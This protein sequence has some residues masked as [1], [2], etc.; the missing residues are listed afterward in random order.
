MS[1]IFGEFL[2]FDQPGHDS[3]R[4]RVFGDEHYA[5]YE[6]AAGYSVVFDPELGRYCYARLS[7]GT[8]QSTGVAAEASPPEGLVRH[9]QEDDEVIAAKAAGKRALRISMAA[10]PGA[11]EINRTFGPAQGLLNGRVLATGTVRGLTILVNFKDLQSTVTRGDVE[12]LL[13]SDNYTSNG[14]I[15]SVRE[16]FRRISS[17]KLDYVNT[18]VGPYTLSRNRQYYVRNLLV[19]EALG[20]AVADGLDLTLFDSRGEGLIDALNV[21]YAG[22]TQYAGELWPHNWSINLRFGNMRTDQYMLSSLGRSPR[23]LSIGTF[24]HETGHLLCRFPDLYD[25]GQREADFRPSAGIGYFCLMGAGNHLDYGRSPAPVCAYLRDLVGWVDQEIDLHQAGDHQV[26][27]G[28]YAT[29]HKYQTS[30]PNEYFLV[31]NRSRV[32][33]DRGGIASGLAIYH[34]DILGSNE[35][36]DGT[37]SRHYQCALLQ[38]DGRR[39][40]E[41]NSN[42]GDPA[43]LFGEFPDVALSSETNPHT[44]EWDGRDSGLTI[45]AIGRP[46]D[47]IRFRTGSQQPPPTSPVGGRA[48]PE[49]RIPDSSSSGVTSDIRIEAPGVV[50]RIIV[51][52]DIRHPYIG[53]L[54]VSLTAPSGRSTELHGRLGMGRDDLIETYDSASPGVLSPMLGEPASGIW[55]LTAK[56]LAPRDVGVLRSWEIELH[57]G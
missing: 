55:R 37:A 11:R 33:L 56:D 10:D 21:L 6:N 27:H 2:T 32:G 50:A 14:N 12:A 7:A 43:D 28:D 23:D 19:E 44:R 8:F 29:I 54:S 13:N 51:K 46:A 48:T 34:C 25:Y 24:C 9:L 20:L 4:L 45:S 40:L 52:V 35:Y 38:A 16:Y 57:L 42:Q 26:T 53:D 39:D 1:A 3:I 5:R 31:E 30:R 18:V 22:Q 36:Q 47:A 17:G 49:L 15:C 41:Q